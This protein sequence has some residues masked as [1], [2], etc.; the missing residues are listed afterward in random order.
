MKDGLAKELADFLAARG[1]SEK[2]EMYAECLH[3]VRRLKKVNEPTVSIV[4]I[5]WKYN[6][7][8][9]ENFKI[10]ERQR[11]FGH[12]L[13]FV[14]N[15]AGDEAF[16]EILP[17]VDTL[18]SL[19]SNTGAYLARNLG[20]VFSSAPLLLFLDDDALPEEDFIPQCLRAFEMYDI[21]S[22]RGA[23]FPRTDNPLNFLPVHYYFG[24]EPLAMF[25][26]VEGLTAYKSDVFFE[27]G[28]WDDGI[29]FG[30]GG[31][32]LGYKIAQARPDLRRQIYYPW[33][34]AYHDYI[35]SI[36]LLAKKAGKQSA[37]KTRLNNIHPDIDDFHKHYMQFRNHPELVVSKDTYDDTNFSDLPARRRPFNRELYQL[38]SFRNM[39]HKY[40]MYE[41]AI[42]EVRAVRRAEAPMIS[43][44][45]S[46]KK[47]GAALIETVR[48]LRD[49]NR[50]RAE[51][52]IVQNGPDENRNNTL[53][54]L[55]DHFVHLR[56]EST[57]A[58]ANNIGSLFARAPI[59]LFL[60]EK[61]IAAPNILGA[62]W[63]AYIQY[64]PIAVRGSCEPLDENNPLNERATHFHPGNDVIPRYGDLTENVSYLSEAFF[65][66][67]GFF[68]ALPD[69]EGIEIASR[70]NLFFNNDFRRQL[71]SPSPVIQMDYAGA[72]EELEQKKRDETDSWKIINH[73]RPYCLGY[74]KAYKNAEKAGM[75]RRLPGKRA[76]SNLS[77]P[78]TASAL[79]G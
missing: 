11:R 35:D 25:A 8:I 13:I 12:E 30:C 48:R 76:V 63:D 66:V 65:G 24:N 20:A 2:C 28:G 42:H 75:F 22:M 52:I 37:S 69:N 10:L 40:G 58:A 39:Q 49:E 78:D 79:N 47:T 29:I 57:T 4:V 67:K 7:L 51:I 54:E 44:V 32:E 34:V 9:L 36:D 55:A 53:Q 50:V 61:A 27:V 16:A 15:G 64:E 71:Y 14:D 73:N 38:L 31:L 1:W 74:L 72:I 62:H 59:L 21:V 6:P 3:D 17:H 19:S 18:V 56:I 43:V 41:R 33:M 26:E 70:L 77:G 45:V 46:A 60:G 5:A 23:I 68:D